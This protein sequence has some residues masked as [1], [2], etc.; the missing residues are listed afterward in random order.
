MNQNVRLSPS[1]TTGQLPPFNE[2]NEETSVLVDWDGP[3][4]LKNPMNWKDARKWAIIT[5]VSFNTFNVYGL[6][7]N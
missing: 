4:D 6:E 7:L 2:R 1:N 5:L 3:N